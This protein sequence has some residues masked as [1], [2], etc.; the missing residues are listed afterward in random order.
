MY[1]WS[2]ELSFTIFLLVV[3]VSQVTAR[4]TKSIVP[5]PLVMGIICTVGFATGLFPKDMMQSANM[6]AVGTIAYNVLVV[7]S[8]TLIDF[9]FLKANI[10]LVTVCVLCSLAMVLVVLILVGLLFGWNMAL[11]ACG[12]VIGGG[13]S[14]AIA[15]RSVYLTHPEISVFP[16]MVFMFQGVFCI[17]IV[18][19][20]LKKEAQATVPDLV[21]NARNE[22]A[23]KLCS[24]IPSGYKT[25]AYY[26]GSVMVISLLNRFLFSLLPTSFGGFLNLSA[27]AA[28]MLL[29]R[30]GLLEE[31][32]L[33]NSDSYG[34]LILGLMGLFAN[35]IANTPLIVMLSLLP[36]VL[37]SLAIAAAALAAGALVSSKILNQRPWLLL[38]MLLNCMMGFPVNSMLIEKA[39]NSRSDNAGKDA[40][41]HKAGSALGISTGLISNALSIVIVCIASI[42]IR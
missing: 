23:V 14:C 7:H 40:I 28:G 42:F 32:P 11:L 9:S 26:L 10:R 29:G 12:S 3:F 39:M 8:G 21:S 33:K 30:L 2:F 13:A 25:T 5:M 38:A 17:P 36:S 41:A 4:K 15:S 24:R 34:L 27:L 35:T 20:A 22:K 31:G 6:I 18:S 1:I 19:F 37:V 16:W